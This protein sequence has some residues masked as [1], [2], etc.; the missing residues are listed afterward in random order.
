MKEN[1]DRKKKFFCLIKQQL[2][3]LKAIQQKLNSGIAKYMSKAFKQAS[4][5]FIEFI[6]L[7][8]TSTS[9]TSLISSSNYSRLKQVSFRGDTGNYGQGETLKFD[10]FQVK[11][12]F[13]YSSV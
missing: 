11:P 10:S 9:V 8:L 7:S 4:D 6:L 5:H 12:I 1:V 3:S 13:F 2:Q